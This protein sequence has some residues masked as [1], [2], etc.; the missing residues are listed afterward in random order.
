[1]AIWHNILG[2]PILSN[3]S[4]VTDVAHGPLVSYIFQCFKLIFY[5]FYLHF[6]KISNKANIKENR[7]QWPEVAAEERQKD[8][9]FK[10][11]LQ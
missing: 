7:M 5:L 2:T 8:T 11:Q 10:I 1:M 6:F 9:K 3:F 4:Q